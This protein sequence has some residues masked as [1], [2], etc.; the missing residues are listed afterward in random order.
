MEWREQR[1]ASLGTDAM[2]GLALA[3]IVAFLILQVWIGNLP[4]L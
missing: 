4:S 1:K 3:I 2:I